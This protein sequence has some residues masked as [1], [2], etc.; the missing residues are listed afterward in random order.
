MN[1]REKLWRAE[2]AIERYPDEMIEEE[3]K[4]KDEEKVKK[5][6]EEQEET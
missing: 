1:E 5:A 3:R 2:E 4:K 6:T